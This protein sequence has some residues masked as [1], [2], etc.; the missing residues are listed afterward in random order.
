M[1]LR[2]PPPQGHARKA[3]EHAV[4]ARSKAGAPRQHQGLVPE[5]GHLGA[6]PCPLLRA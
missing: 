3:K 1:S 4:V 6:P 5:V 2:R